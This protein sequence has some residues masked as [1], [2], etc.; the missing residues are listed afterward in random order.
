MQK[1]VDAWAAKNQVEVQADF[2]TAVGQKDILTVAAEAQVK[3]QCEPVE[4]HCTKVVG[5]NVPP[6]TSMLDLQK[7]WEDL[8]PPTGTVYSY[9]LRPFHNAKPHVA[10][11]SAPPEIA[12]QL[13]NRGTMPTMSATLKSGQTIDQVIAWASDE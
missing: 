3:L 1:Q 10:A 7:I 5:Y 8:E 13:H 11:L 2:I 9:P 12:V 6:F 4:A